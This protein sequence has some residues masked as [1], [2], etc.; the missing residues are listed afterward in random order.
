MGP[1]PAYKR[2]DPGGELARDRRH[3]AWI[4]ERRR[5]PVCVELLSHV[6]RAFVFALP[7]TGRSCNSQRP[8]EDL[9]GGRVL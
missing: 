5:G 4:T 7:A 6:A 2:Y 8:P 1:S 9:S 3:A